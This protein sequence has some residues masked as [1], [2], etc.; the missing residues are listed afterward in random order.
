MDSPDSK[1]WKILLVEDEQDIAALVS[2]HLE[3]QLV[4]NLEVDIEISVII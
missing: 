3:D 4:M 1:R 2:M